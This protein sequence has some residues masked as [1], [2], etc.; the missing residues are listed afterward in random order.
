QAAELPVSVQEAIVS[1][2]AGN[3]FFMEELTW[4][5]VQQGDHSGT[6]PLPD[7]VEAALMARIDLLP[8]E[9]KHLV[10]TAAV[11]GSEV[12]VPLLQRLVGLSEDVLQRGLAQLQAKEFL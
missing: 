3:P 9:Q 8:A 7:T 5:A 4:A 6:L 2:A 10:Q 12:P 11:I 1:R